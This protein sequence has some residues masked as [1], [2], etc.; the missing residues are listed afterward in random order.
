MQVW[1]ARGAQAIAAWKERLEATPA[2]VPDMVAAKA[3][4]WAA[5]VLT[6][7]AALRKQVDHVVARLESLP[8]PSKSR[9]PTLKGIEK[10][11]SSLSGELSGGSEKKVAKLQDQLALALALDKG[12]LLADARGVASEIYLPEVLGWCQLAR[13]ESL[14]EQVAPLLSPRA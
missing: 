9:A 12:M 7:R 8:P 10:L 2:L 11:R 1:E 5:E 14:E 4:R 6:A 13:R 3:L